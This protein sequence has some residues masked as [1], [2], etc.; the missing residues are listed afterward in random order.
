MSLTMSIVKIRGNNRNRLRHRDRRIFRRYTGNDI[1]EYQQPITIYQEMQMV[2]TNGDTFFVSLFKASRGYET[3]FG[4]T[5]EAA[6]RRLIG[7]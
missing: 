3:A 1:P 7:H 2:Q 5:S 4:A 6:I